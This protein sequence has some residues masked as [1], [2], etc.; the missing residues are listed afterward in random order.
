MVLL[1]LLLPPATNSPRTPA[2]SRS[3]RYTLIKQE[4]DLRKLY[5]DLSD[6]PAHRAVEIANSPTKPAKPTVLQQHTTRPVRCRHCFGFY[7][8]VHNHAQSCAYHPGEYLVACPRWCKE[9]G[10]STKCMSHRTKRWTC[11]DLRE[12]GENSSNGCSRRFHVA[13]SH[14][15]EYKLTVERLEKEYQEDDARLEAELQPIRDRDWVREAGRVKK[16]QLDGIA[17][18]LTGERAIVAR[19]EALKRG[20][21]IGDAGKKKQ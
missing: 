20:R 6:K 17:N 5:P 14:D 11:C 2:S 1:P 10:A 21:R 12:K 9:Q 7:L 3:P 8:E 13:P 19:F 15:P 18:E 4:L 16:D